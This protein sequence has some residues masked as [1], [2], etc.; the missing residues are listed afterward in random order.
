MNDELDSGPAANLVG[1]MVGSTAVCRIAKNAAVVG[2]EPQPCEG[3]IEDM[4]LSA[5][6]EQG[7]KP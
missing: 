7:S 5:L 3:G 2:A 4:L 1:G 6:P